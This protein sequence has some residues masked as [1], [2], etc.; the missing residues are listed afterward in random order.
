MWSFA[1]PSGKYLRCTETVDEAQEEVSE[2]I[3]IEK[4]DVRVEIA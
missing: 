2:A 4:E 3:I 1:P